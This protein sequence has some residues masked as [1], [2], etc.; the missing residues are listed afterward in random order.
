[1][2]SINE[3][4]MEKVGKLIAMAAA[5]VAGSIT[6]IAG[7]YILVSIIIGGAIMMLKILPAIALMV[8]AGLL[9]NYLTKK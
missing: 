6:I 2:E 7:C 4:S 5:V 9:A 8:V 3:S 1:M